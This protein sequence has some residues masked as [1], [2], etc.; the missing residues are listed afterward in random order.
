MEEFFF[1]PVKDSFLHLNFGFYPCDR[2]IYCDI[3]LCLFYVPH[4]SPP[5]SP[6]T[7]EIFWGKVKNRGCRKSC[8]LPVLKLFEGGGGGREG[9]AYKG[10]KKGES[11]PAYPKDPGGG[12]ERETPTS[13]GDLVT[14]CGECWLDCVINL[15]MLTTGLRAQ[16]LLQSRLSP[17]GLKNEHLCVL[18]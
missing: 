17:V 3:N 5:A 10:E 14:A 11:F 15:R 4:L 1:P 8:S 2:I 7:S 13:N 16:S 12:E 18:C 6:F 9:I